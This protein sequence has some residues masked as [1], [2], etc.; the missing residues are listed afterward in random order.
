MNNINSLIAL[1]CQPQHED[2]YESL[3]SSWQH[4]NGVNLTQDELEG[5]AE[6]VGEY[7][8]QVGRERAYDRSMSR[9]NGR[10]YGNE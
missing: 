2:C 5:V 3:V 8:A 1:L 4:C 9:A 7:W 6:T 10:A